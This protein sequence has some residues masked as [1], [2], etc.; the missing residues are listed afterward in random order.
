MLLGGKNVAGEMQKLNRLTSEIRDNMN[1]MST[2]V[3]QISNS[4]NDVNGLAQKNKDSI[5][6]LAREVGVFIV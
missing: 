1:E 5:D 3:T 4:V 6:N 2:G